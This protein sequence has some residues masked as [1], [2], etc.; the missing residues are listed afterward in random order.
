MLTVIHLSLFAQSRIDGV[1][2]S[3][4]HKGVDLFSCWFAIHGIVSSY[5]ETVALLSKGYVDSK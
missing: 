3:L 2:C 5:V 4:I 1:I